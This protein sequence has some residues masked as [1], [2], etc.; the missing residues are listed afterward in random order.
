MFKAS[1][2]LTI[3]NR[4]FTF[5]GITSKLVF[6]GSPRILIFKLVSEGVI[7]LHE[8][9]FRC[10]LGLLTRPVPVPPLRVYLILT[11]PKVLSNRQFDCNYKSYFEMLRFSVQFRVRPFKSV[12]LKL[13]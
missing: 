5:R 12:K 3:L 13:S 9:W 1:S 2:M 4:I 10:P 7:I 11:A 8:I 6:K